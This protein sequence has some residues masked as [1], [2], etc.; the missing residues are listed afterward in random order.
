M[1]ATY[2]QSVFVNGKNGG[3]MC[4]ADGDIDKP[5]ALV[6]VRRRVIGLDDKCR[7]RR[8]HVKHKKVAYK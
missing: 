5:I 1:E 7:R 6:Q 8:C 3:L 2:S 4:Y